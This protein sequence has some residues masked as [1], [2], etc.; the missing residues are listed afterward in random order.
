MLT[1][2]QMIEKLLKLSDTE[3]NKMVSE[4]DNNEETLK[5]YPDEKFCI[6]KED[7]SYHKE[8][9][10]LDKLLDDAVKHRGNYS[11]QF[12][13][14]M[15]DDKNNVTLDNKVSN[16]ELRKAMKKAFIHITNYWYVGEPGWRNWAEMVFFNTRDEVIF[17]FI[18]SNRYAAQV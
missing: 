6:Y 4:I 18:Y 8:Y 11:F 1:K 17:E 2:E 12:T 13:F 10:N 9:D 15:I 3:L 5:H 16:D 7:G 14:S